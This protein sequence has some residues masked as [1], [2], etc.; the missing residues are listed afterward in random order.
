MSWFKKPKSIDLSSFAKRLADQPKPR[1]SSTLGSADL[2]LTYHRPIDIQ[3]AVLDM[4]SIWA[5]LGDERWNI[6][7]RRRMNQIFRGEVP[8]E[9]QRYLATLRQSSPVFREEMFIGF[10]RE[11]SEP[12]FVPRHIFKNHSYILGG[13]G[14]GKTSHAIAQLL[15]QLAEEYTDRK[16]RVHPAPP[17]LIIDLKPTGDRYLRS[18]A[19][20]LAE[21]RGQ[22]LQFFSVDPH[23]ESLQFSPFYSLRSVLYPLKFGELLLNA[24]SMIYPEG[25]GSDFFTNEQRSQLN[26]NLYHDR[27]K[28]MNEMIAFI[29]H[30]T[31]GASGNKDARG[32]YSALQAL[33]YAKNI[34]TSGTPLGQG[35][36]LDFDRFFD[37]REVLY[38][39][40][41][42]RFLKLVSRDV[43]KLLLFCLLE[44][45]SQREKTGRKTQCYVAIDE[46]HQLAARNIVEMAADARS[47]GIAFIFSHQSAS[48]LKTMD[49]DLLGPVFENTC[50][51]Q[52]LDLEDP[53]M[54]E[55]FQAIAGRKTEYKYGGSES[56][57]Q[58]E[59]TSTMQSATW[60]YNYG[61]S[62]AVSTDAFS[63]TVM[64]SSQSFGGSSGSGQGKSQS[65][66]SS[67]TSSWEEEKVP[68]LTP[69]MITAVNDTKLL[70]L[71]HIKGAGANCLTPTGGVPLLVQGLYPFDEPTAER[72]A[73]EPWPSKSVENPE[74]YY[75]EARPSITL[76]EGQ[77]ARKPK[78]LVQSG[79][80]AS[81][82]STSPQKFDGANEGD[83]RKLQGRV[84]DLAE[85]L[86]CDMIE[87]PMNVRDFSRVCQVSI[88][89][90]V[91]VGAT[92]GL[93]LSTRQD[94]LSV[95]EVRLLKQALAKRESSE[96]GS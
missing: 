95:T 47:S 15:I 18:L 65:R 4:E 25:Y 91:E 5:G 40:L 80:T 10:N 88:K 73:K 23:Y 16:G 90:I 32:L 41:D 2:A 59:G 74:W 8:C 29:R 38:V 13:S 72:M 22:T 51:K 69:E 86:A 60:G 9:F 50:Y 42:S 53:R 82:P 33:E 45:A 28:T 35:Q 78:Q 56:E 79:G 70:S 64:T 67:K 3:M 55:R 24:L 31:A 87:E 96:G 71:V 12:I 21:A 36:L 46:F 20:Q 75:E 19:R 11:T 77:V 57:S 49:A 85:Q 68:G 89:T 52:C 54:I 62:T 6:L 30:S 66:G 63:P 61:N 7:K 44:T 58:S 14:S 39:H 94:E 81:A 1:L 76:S 83:R 84:R 93:D 26:K 92:I 17:I 37:N 27:P 34:H 48:S 43:G